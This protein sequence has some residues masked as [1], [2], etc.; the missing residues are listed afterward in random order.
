MLWGFSH[1]QHLADYFNFPSKKKKNLIS[2]K[3]F[4]PWGFGKWKPQTIT[5][6]C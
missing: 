6:T 5:K 4:F 2:N 3:L 1:K